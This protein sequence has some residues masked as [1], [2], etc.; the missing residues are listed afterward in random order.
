MLTP[1]SAGRMAALLAPVAVVAPRVAGPKARAPRTLRA[2]AFRGARV[3]ATPKVGPSPNPRKLF[4][5]TLPD[6]SQSAM[7]SAGD[8]SVLPQE[9]GLGAASAPRQYRLELCAAVVGAHPVQHA[10]SSSF[11]SFPVLRNPIL[12]CARHKNSP[13]LLSLL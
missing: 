10:Q 7:R 6:T 3:T 4:F 5:Y 1:Q 9:A 13:F 8:V 12:R 11:A 2:S